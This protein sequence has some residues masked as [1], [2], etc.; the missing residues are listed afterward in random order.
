MLARPNSKFQITH[1]AGK[2]GAQEQRKYLHCLHNQQKPLH[3]LWGRAK[4]RK[5]RCPWCTCKP[6]M[7]GLNRGNEGS[8]GKGKQREQGKTKGKVRSF[9]KSQRSRLEPSPPRV[10]QRSGADKR[11]APLSPP[12]PQTPHPQ[13]RF[14]I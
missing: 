10:S 3:Q 6:E 5:R 12:R 7:A 8:A 14:R 13:S 11:R 1:P 2:R 9:L 4:P